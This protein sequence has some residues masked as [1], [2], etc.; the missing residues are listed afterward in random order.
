VHHVGPYYGDILRCPAHKT[1]SLYLT[2][3]L[4]GLGGQRNSQAALPREKDPL[5]IVQEA[6]WAPRSIRRGAEYFV[7][8][9]KFDPL[10]TQPVTSRHT[11]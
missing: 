2:W 11:D 10:T 7:S 9:P 1:L 5:D 8:R 6:G 3:A 4:D